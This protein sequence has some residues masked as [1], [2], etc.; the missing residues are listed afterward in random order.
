LQEDENPDIP[1]KLEGAKKEEVNRSA[2]PEI[3]VSAM[4]CWR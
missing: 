2:R 1:K 3:Q 4:R